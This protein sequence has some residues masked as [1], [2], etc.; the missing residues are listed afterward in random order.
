M[1]IM[2]KTTLTTLS[3]SILLSACNLAPRYEQPNIQLPSAQFKYD[4]EQTGVQAAKLGW[5]DYFADPRL[6]R[7]I[8]LALQNNTDLRI[9]NL[10]VE[11]VRAQ[12]AI[13]RASLLPSISASGSGSRTG[14]EATNQITES[15]SVG[16]GV[17]SFELDLWGRVRNNS[18]AALESYFS[19]KAGRDSTHLSLIASVAKAH[20]NEI[21]AENAMQLAKKVLTTREESYRLAKLRH[22]SGV[23]SN[24]DLR[25]QEALIEQAKA[26]Y[27][28]ALQ[29]REQ[30]RNALEL[31]I[32]QALPADLPEALPLDKQFTI[33][34]LPAGLSSEV[35]LNRP[36]IIVAEHN[37]KQ[38]NAN[39][40]AAR[41]AFFPTISLTSNLGF[42]SNQ[43]SGLFDTVNKSWTFAGNVSLPIFNWGSNVANLKSANVAQKKAIVAYEAAVE[44][45]FKDV[46]DALVARYSLTQQYESS[47]KQSQAYAEALRLTRLRYQYGVAS[48][49]DLLDAERS[50]Y[51][52]DSSTLSMELSLAENLADVYKV[53]GGGLK[54]HT[55]TEANQ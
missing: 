38:A 37:L 20:F 24:I 16:L 21:Y 10:N 31:L 51:S 29:A 3:A 52:A 11:Q 32:S 48:S 42:G 8:E 40:G 5:A 12:Y 27:A 14:V 45:A 41:A 1:N 53:L 33:R 6:H 49:L 25:Q 30:A 17:S 2:L 9:A 36:D 4:S 19:T 46:A 44:S 47:V 28:S 39:I 15:Y 23:I 34:Q 43:L 54:R 50:S 55:E 18:R 35:L 7:L 22:E 13:A 26:S